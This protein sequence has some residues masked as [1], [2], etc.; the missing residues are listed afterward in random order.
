[1][2]LLRRPLHSVLILSVVLGGSSWTSLR[3][4]SAARCQ[5]GVLEILGT[6]GK[7]RAQGPVLSLRIALSA[8][9]LTL[10]KC[11]WRGVPELSWRSVIDDLN[12]SN[13]HRV[14]LIRAEYHGARWTTS[15]RKEAETQRWRPLPMLFSSLGSS[16]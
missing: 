12:T 3:Y 7:V 14:L 2:H 13:Q 15:W 16:R 5:E 9:R 8:G 6:R 1:M 10:R 11:S 4:W